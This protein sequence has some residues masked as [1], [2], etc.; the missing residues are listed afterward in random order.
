MQGMAP[1]QIQ[2]PPMGGPGAADVTLP[3]DVATEYASGRK[4]TA[5]APYGHPPIPIPASGSLRLRPPQRLRQLSQ[6]APPTSC[7]QRCSSA[8]GSRR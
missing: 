6:R 8:S 7:S 3:D 4:K 2:L 1:P 5:G